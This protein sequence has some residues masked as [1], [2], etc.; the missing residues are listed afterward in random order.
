ML[1][2][3]VTQSNENFEIDDNFSIEATY[4]EVP[5]GAGRKNS[6]GIN[7]LGQRSSISILQNRYNLCLPRSS[8]VGEA[9]VNLKEDA[10][11]DAKKYGL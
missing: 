8:V 10:T 9:F 7:V 4:V 6:F 1:V 11:D 3:S 2:S 5:L